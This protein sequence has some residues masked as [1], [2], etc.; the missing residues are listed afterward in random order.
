MRTYIWQN[1]K[2]P[3]FT[4]N[5]EIILPLLSQVR[6]KQGLLL[7]KMR[8]IG[9]ENI[10]KTLLN[11]LTEDVIK[12]NEIEGLQF[13]T[14]Q[15]RSSI[16]KRLGLDIGKNIYVNRNIQGTVDVMFDA[17]QNFKMELSEKRLLSWQAAMFPDGMSGLYKIHIGKYRDDANGAMQVVSGAIGHEKIHY[18][19]PPAKILKKEMKKFL[20]FTNN[21]N[22]YV[23]LVIKAAI[24]H[25][26]FVI[27]HPFEDGNGRIARCLTDMLLARSENSPYRFYSMSS[28]IQKKRNEYYKILELTQKDS[29][30]ITS[31]IIWFLKTM[32]EA[33]EN[34]EKILQE[35]IIKSEF[36]Q[37]H[38]N[39]I[40]NER[41]T[42]I[43]NLLTNHFEG[44]LTTIKWAKICHC[45]QDAATRDIND[46]I[47]KNILEKQGQAR[48]THYILNLS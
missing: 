33:I 24:L 21:D 29:L 11:V 36:W 15:V 48:A 35:T 40:M 30:D 3:N 31:W 46:L 41:Q 28:E 16:A 13:N 18:E 26:W 42:K 6:L 4:Y 5:T 14:E 39:T 37:K 44:K 34:S 1:P 38:K 27:L 12:S 9:F 10:D 23:D 8:N 32:E 19:A 43:L 47:S 20:D 2:F 7:G 25:L 22:D 17:T 45:S